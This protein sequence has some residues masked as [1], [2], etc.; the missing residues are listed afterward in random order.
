MRLFVSNLDGS[1]ARPL[2]DGSG[3]V[4]GS[5][6]SPDGKRIAFADR[7]ANHVLNVDVMNADGSDR[8]HL[9]H[10]AA[11]EGSAQMPA[12][13][14]DGRNL[15]VQSGAPDKPAHLWIVDASTGAAQ[16]L[17]AH[18]DPYND[19]VPAWFPDGKRIAYQSDRTGKMEIWVM[20]AD[21]SSPR[22]ITR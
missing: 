12:W 16:K 14:A 6:W 10:F 5:R 2:T 4:W 11:S 20:N 9:T 8:R 21:G 19:E 3:A 1:D 22:Q 7:D 18:D 17:A 13:S 15:A